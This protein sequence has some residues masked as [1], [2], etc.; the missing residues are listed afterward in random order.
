MAHHDQCAT[1]CDLILDEKRV[2]LQPQRLNSAA[3]EGGPLE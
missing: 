2:F 1:I 3:A